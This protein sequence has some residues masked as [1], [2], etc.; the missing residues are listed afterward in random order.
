MFPRP[1]VR[2]RFGEFDCNEYWGYVGGEFG[3]VMCDDS[4]YSN[5]CPQGQVCV[6]SELDRV[7]GEQVRAVFK[8]DLAYVAL[9]DRAS[10]M[11]NFPYQYGEKIEPLKYGEGLTSRIIET[12]AS[13]TT[14]PRNDEIS[15]R[16]SRAPLVIGA[17]PMNGVIT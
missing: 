7:V 8:S 13:R 2:W 1:R 4:C 12:I 15:E 11:I 16:M 9:L 17:P 14:A 5:G 6:R 10:G 3:N